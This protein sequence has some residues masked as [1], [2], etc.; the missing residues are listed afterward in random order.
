MAKRISSLSKTKNIFRLFSEHAARLIIWLIKVASEIDPVEY[1]KAKCRMQKAKGTVNKD[2]PD[3]KHIRE[4]QE[5]YGSFDKRGI[6][7]HHPERDKVYII[8]RVS[9]DVDFRS[10][11]IS[12]IDNDNAS[13]KILSVGCG[14]GSWE[15]EM[16]KK[17]GRV[18]GIDLNEKGLVL[19]EQ[20]GLS[21]VNADAHQLPFSDN[22]FDTVVFSESIGDMVIEEA[23]KEAHRVLRP[24]ERIIT[25]TKFTSEKKQLEGALYIHYPA[26]EIKSALEKTGFKDIDYYDI[27]TP[28]SMD[29]MSLY[30]AFKPNLDPCALQDISAASTVGSADSGRGGGY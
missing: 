4:I 29:I 9:Q 30:I 7:F 25:T 16:N 8:S 3:N 17:Q 12:V 13:Q 27:I 2:P 10:Y 15:I 1:D 26:Q 24:G 21:V 23:F 11:F 5:F 14:F 22:Y 6:N 18:I 19:S 20:K 28:W